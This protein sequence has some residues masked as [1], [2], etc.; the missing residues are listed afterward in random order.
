M[1]LSVH[2]SPITPSHGIRTFRDYFDTTFPRPDTINDLP[3]FDITLSDIL[4]VDIKL[5]TTDLMDEHL[6]MDGDT[7]KILVVSSIN[8]WGLRHY[9]GNRAARCVFF[10][11]VILVDSTLFTEPWEFQAWEKRSC[12]PA[13]FY[14]AKISFFSRQQ[15]WGC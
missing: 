1:S 12:T 8:V 4:A 10:N 11:S 5:L 14:M 13:M 15:L 9:H 6:T 7:L 2:F 3:G